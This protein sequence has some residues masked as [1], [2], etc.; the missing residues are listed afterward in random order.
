MA[1]LLLV[2]APCRHRFPAVLVAGLRHLS[3]WG[4]LEQREVRFGFPD[5]TYRKKGSLPGIRRDP[6]TG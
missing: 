4:L 6:W 1:T 5:I 3:A 2:T